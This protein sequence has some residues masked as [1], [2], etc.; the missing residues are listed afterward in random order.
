MRLMREEEEEG[1]KPR[2]WEEWPKGEE[3]R[4]E[5]RREGGWVMG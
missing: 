2:T 4:R 1:D 3:G 5:G